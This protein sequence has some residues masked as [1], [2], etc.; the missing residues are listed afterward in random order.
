MAQC[1]RHPLCLFLS[2]SSFDGRDPV[3]AATAVLFIRK[4]YGESFTAG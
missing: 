1:E 2:A 4:D 3:S